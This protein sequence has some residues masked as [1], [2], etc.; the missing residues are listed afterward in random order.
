MK[1]ILTLCMVVKE[2]EVLLGM[3]KRGFGVGK[4]NGFGG[5]IEENETIEEGAVRELKEEIGINAVE[6][7]KVGILGFSVLD[8]PVRLEVH[9]FKVS[10]F[11]GEPTESEEM[12]PQWF[13]QEAIP[14]SEMWPDDK[15]WLPIVLNEKLFTGNFLFDKPRNSKYSDKIIKHE[16]TEVDYI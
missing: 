1:K 10:K 8:D 11:T 14:F 5:K 13:A 4:W 7:K 2:G 6:M 12:K 15:Y 9:V 3:K 16:L